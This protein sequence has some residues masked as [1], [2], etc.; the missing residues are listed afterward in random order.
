MLIVF[1]Q[2]IEIFVDLAG[3]FFHVNQKFLAHGCV[4]STNAELEGGELLLDELPDMLGNLFKAPAGL[5]VGTLPAVG[6]VELA[7][8]A[9]SG[10]GGGGLCGAV[11]CDLQSGE[12]GLILCVDGCHGSGIAA[13]VG[14][15]LHAEPAEFLLQL[16]QG[17]AVSEILHK[18]SSLIFLCQGGKI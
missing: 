7:A 8:V 2:L 10:L 9:V 3:C 18:K 11:V 5:V 16:V 1:G 4:M 14:V 12:Q 17:G 6:G 13:A 15:V